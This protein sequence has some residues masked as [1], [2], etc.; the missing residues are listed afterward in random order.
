MIL[1]AVRFENETGLTD[2]YPSWRSL[3]GKLGHLFCSGHLLKIN[4][5][6]RPATGPL[7]SCRQVCQEETFKILGPRAKASAFMSTSRD[8]STSVLAALGDF[9]FLATSLSCTSCLI[10]GCWILDHSKERWSSSIL[11]SLTKRR[12]LGMVISCKPVT[13][14]KMSPEDQSKPLA[15]GEVLGKASLPQTHPGHQVT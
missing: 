2:R 13:M 5:N 15:C 9:L 6:H 10:M 12:Y 14:I 11:P 3:L 1:K 8:S 7:L 4:S